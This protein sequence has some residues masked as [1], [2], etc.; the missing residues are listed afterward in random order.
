MYLKQSFSYYKWVLQPILSLTVLLN[1]VSS[2]SNFDIA[3]LS[4]CTKFF[5]G[6]FR[7]SDKKFNEDSKNVVK[8]IIFLLQVGFTGDFLPNCPFKLCFLQ[9]KL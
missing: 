5:S 9:F 6:F 8:T 4:D 7:L 1:C 2:N 3:F